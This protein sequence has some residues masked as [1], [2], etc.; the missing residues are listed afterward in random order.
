MELSMK[1]LKRFASKEDA[2]YRHQRLSRWRRMQEEAC[3]KFVKDLPREGKPKISF[4]FRFEGCRIF[5]YGRVADSRMNNSYSLCM[6]AKDMA[7]ASVQGA[8]VKVHG[9]LGYDASNRG[10]TTVVVHSGAYQKG[11]AHEDVH[12]RWESYGRI[13]WS[14]YMESTL[15]LKEEA[16]VEGTLEMHAIRSMHL[17]SSHEERAQRRRQLG[18]TERWPRFERDGV[19]KASDKGL[20]RSQSKRESEEGDSKDGVFEADKSVNP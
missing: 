18:H 5:A 4:N 9:C 12:G 1:V 6:C 13:L 17:W 16:T 14:F 20:R 3:I 15:A 7:L 11:M 10:W 19:A 2:N 8:L